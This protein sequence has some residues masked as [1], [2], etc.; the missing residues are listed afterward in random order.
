MGCT[1]GTTDDEQADDDEA[2]A[3]TSPSET[4][5]NSPSTSTTGP[6]NTSDTSTSETSTST[7]ETST[8]DTGTGETEGASCDHN[9]GWEPNHDAMT[10]CMVTWQTVSEWSA[11]RMV[12]DAYLCPGEGDWYHFDVESLGYTEHFLYLRGLVEDAGLCGAQ[13]DEPVIPAGPEYA[14]TIEVYRVDGIKLNLLLSTT[15]DDGVLP[16]GGFGEDYAHELLIHVFSPNPKAE[17]SYR[18]S[19]E[20][21][22][23]DGEDECEC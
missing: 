4:S 13:C 23:Y 8:S 15:D 21:R 11:S 18:L 7:S 9:D 16:L 20:I 19:V 10:P 12:D 3:E 6:S 5:T 22:N 2:V 14:M 17:Y 1:I